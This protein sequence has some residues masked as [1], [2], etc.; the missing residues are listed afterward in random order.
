MTEE[1][2]DSNVDFQS[3]AGNIFMI[4]YSFTGKMNNK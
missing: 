4:I 1:T 3:I 2:V